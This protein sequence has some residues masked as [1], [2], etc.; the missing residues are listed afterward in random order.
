MTNSDQNFPDF[1]EKETLFIIPVRVL[2]N[3]VK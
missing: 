3:N 1:T 2:Y